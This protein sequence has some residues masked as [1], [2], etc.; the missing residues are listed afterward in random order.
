MARGIS[1]RS[2]SLECLSSRCPPTYVWWEPHNGILQHIFYQPAG[3]S[4]FDVPSCRSFFSAYGHELTLHLSPDKMDSNSD[5]RYSVVAKPADSAANVLPITHCRFIFDTASCDRCNEPSLTPSLLS[6]GACHIK[7][8]STP[9]TVLGSLAE[10]LECVWT[11]SLC[12][13]TCQVLLHL[14]TVQSSSGFRAIFHT[15]CASCGRKWLTGHRICASNLR[16]AVVWF[17]RSNL[18]TYCCMSACAFSGVRFHFRSRQSKPSEVVQITPILCAKP[19][20]DQFFHPSVYWI[21]SCPKQKSTVQVQGQKQS[22]FSSCVVFHG[23]RTSAPQLSQKHW[24][25]Q[26]LPSMQVPQPRC[27]RQAMREAGQAVLWRMFQLRAIHTL[28]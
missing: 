21:G 1:R 8:R 15:A 13:P 20:I 9:P 27:L 18:S 24:S 26:T 7:E 17:A 16:K 6:F 23:H 22:Q 2:H 11:L 5:W 25:C 10:T 14:R 19:T 28:T 12:L 4:W 3:G